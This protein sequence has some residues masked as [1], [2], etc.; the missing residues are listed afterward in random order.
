MKANDKKPTPEPK[1]EEI[2]KAK[3][4]YHSDNF[5]FT[6]LNHLPYFLYPVVIEV[7]QEYANLFHKEKL[8]EE[9]KAF[10]IWYVSPPAITLILQSNTDEDTILCEYLNTLNTK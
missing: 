3:V 10:L 1:P 5:A 7:M 2:L 9:L 4:K 6:G 8:R